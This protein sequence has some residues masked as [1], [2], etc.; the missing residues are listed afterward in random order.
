[1]AGI[2]RKQNEMKVGQ[3]AA[4]QH[5]KKRNR[6]ADFQSLIVYIFIVT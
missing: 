3:M 5:K 2:E 6:F 4:F 1:M